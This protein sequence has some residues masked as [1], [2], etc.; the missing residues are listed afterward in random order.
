MSDFIGNISIVNFK[1]IRQAYLENCARINLIIGK[2]N[3]G[4]SNILEALSLFSLPFLRE[5]RAKKITQMIRCENLSELFHFGNTE[6]SIFVVM[7]ALS[8]VVKYNPDKSLAV[9]TNNGANQHIYQIDKNLRFRSDRSK[10]EKPVVKRY[11]FPGK[12][13]FAG[14]HLNFQ[15][16]PYGL[17]NI[18]PER[19]QSETIK[20]I[21]F[22]KAVIGS[23]KDS[24]LLF[25]EPEAHCFLPFTTQITQEMIANTRNQYFMTTYSP[26]MINN[27]L[28]N[29]GKELAIFKVHLVNHETVIHR[30]AENELD[31]LFQK[32]VDLF[33]SE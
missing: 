15:M 7:D 13:I 27:L 33:T 25:E 29:A 26:F 21:D 24:I 9:E 32:G 28:E 22:F 12:T 1:S 6:D 18:N 14:R 23:N 2:L 10:S 16:P 8:C 3:S 4:K 30:L 20:R 19:S 17:N 31:D 11:I 5:S